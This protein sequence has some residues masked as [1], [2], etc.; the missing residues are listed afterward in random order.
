MSKIMGDAN[1]LEMLNKELEKSTKGSK[2]RTKAEPASAKTEDKP[3]RTFRVNLALR[4]DIG[5]ELK[6]RATE[7]NRSVNNYIEQLLLDHFEK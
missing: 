7:E 5:E 2:T 6:R 1:P 3:K 4:Q